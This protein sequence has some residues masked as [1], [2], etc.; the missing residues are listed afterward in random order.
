MIVPSVHV[1][2]N[3]QLGPRNYVILVKGVEVVW[4][5]LMSDR[6]LVINP[7]TATGRIDGLPAKEPAFGLP[8]L[9]I[10]T[11]QRDAAAT[12]GYT[13]GDPT[14]ALST[15]LSEVIRSFLPELLTRQ[16]TKERVDRVAQT[17]PRLFEDLVPKV[18]SLG[19]IQRVL[20]QLLR[21]RVPIKDL[22]TV[23][24]ALAD[25]AGASRDADV[26]NETVRVALGRAI[27]RQHQTEQGDLPSIWP[28]PS[29]S[30]SCRR[31][32]APSKARSWP[33][34]P[35]TRRRWPPASPGPSKRRWHNL[36]FCV[37][38]C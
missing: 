30:G 16:Q 20:K 17:S 28:R 22:T 21:E 27:C 31:W 13:V 6:L 1:A 10:R 14:T 18:L 2:D 3:P 25:V 4:A 38:Q 23:L 9:W 29:R 33:S 5:E 19:D 34:I 37:H 24:E 26:L 32:S 36:C 7:G 35:R 11:E 12:A 8:A 15:H